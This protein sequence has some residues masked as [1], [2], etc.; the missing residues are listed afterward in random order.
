MLH[1]DQQ[2]EREDMKD[3]SVWPNSWVFLQQ[4]L[5]LEMTLFSK[6]ALHNMEKHSQLSQNIWYFVKIKR[7][8]KLRIWFCYFCKKNC[9]LFWVWPTRTPF[10]HKW[11]KKIVIFRGFSKLFFRTAGFQSKFLTLVE[12]PNTL[13]WK[14]AKQ[15]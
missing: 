15:N 7:F 13:H 8:W 1:P 12:F 5:R 9:F 2:N 14:L 10:L 6:K 11:S 4:L 3:R